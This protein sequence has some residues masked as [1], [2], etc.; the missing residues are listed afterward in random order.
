MSQMRFA[1]TAEYL[2]TDHVMGVVGLFQN[3]R[4]FYWLG[5]TGPPASAIIFGDRI[6]QGLTATSADIQPF[7]IEIIILVAERRIGPLISEYSELF[8]C[9]PGFPLLRSEE[10]RVGRERRAGE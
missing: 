9:E 10:R 7:F 4:T 8:R 5:K 3:I 6:E 2:G 1:I